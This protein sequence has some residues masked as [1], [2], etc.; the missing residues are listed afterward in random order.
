LGAGL[1]RYGLALKAGVSKTVVDYHEQV[2]GR[3]RPGTL[4]KLAR[5]LGPELLGGAGVGRQ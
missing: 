4:A 1:S 2:G 3:P 5:V